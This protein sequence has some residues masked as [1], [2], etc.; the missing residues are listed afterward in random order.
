MTIK[1]DYSDHKEI[2]K[3]GEKLSAIGLG[4]WAIHDYGS[5]YPVFIYGLENGIDNIDTAEMYDNGYAEEF[6]GKIIKDYGRENVFITTK[7]LPS[8]L[9]SREKVL[10]A[11]K[12]S[13]K[14]LGVKYVDLFLIHWPNPSISI[15]KQVR[16]FEIL[17]DKGITRYIGVSNFDKKNLEKALYAT[18]Y[19]EIVVDQVHYSV[20]YREVEKEL[21]PYAIENNI[22][23]QAYTP[24][25]K[26]NVIYSDIIREI[27]SKY[28]KTPI[29]IALNYLISHP[30]V[31]AIPKTEN[32]VH[33]RE[34]LGSMGWRL[35][36]EDLEVL[37]NI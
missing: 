29:Q 16:N 27:A 23:I 32:I 7:M 21:L 9:Y 28:D 20:L 34:I 12:R 18:S 19:A 31:I 11:G 6:V 3:T 33:L 26:G 25:E 2:G 36:R 30:R 35:S 37:S 10:R 15:E 17:V 5:A 22:T 8:H 13:L 24:L 14:R 4:T 1:I